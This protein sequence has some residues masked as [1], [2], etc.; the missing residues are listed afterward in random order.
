MDPLAEIIRHAEAIFF[1]GGDESRY[2]NWWRNS[3]VQDPV[4][5]PVAAGK[6][7]GETSAALAIQGEYIY[8]SENDLC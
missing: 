4:N 3:P 1:A 2:V 7:L 5:D 8:T 6:P